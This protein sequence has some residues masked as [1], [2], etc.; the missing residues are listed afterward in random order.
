MATADLGEQ[1]SDLQFGAP[2]TWFER[3]EDWAAVRAISE[4][5]AETAPERET[6][7]DDGPVR[8]LYARLASNYEAERTVPDLGGGVPEDRYSL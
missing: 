5:A 6:G 1:R 3:M 8:A 2:V 7:T 4:W